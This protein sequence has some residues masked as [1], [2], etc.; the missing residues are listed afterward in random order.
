MG[1]VALQRSRGRS[2]HPLCLRR[3]SLHGTQAFPLLRSG[4]LGWKDVNLRHLNLALLCKGHRG[5]ELCQM[6]P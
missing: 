5:R 4:K 2:R 6:L 3:L 1:L